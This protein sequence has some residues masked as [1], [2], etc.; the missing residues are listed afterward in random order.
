MKYVILE[1]WVALEC[2]YIICE[3]GTDNPMTFDTKEEA[4]AVKDEYAQ[5]GV[6]IELPN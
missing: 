1:K 5:D 3:E 6:V 4:E 2:P